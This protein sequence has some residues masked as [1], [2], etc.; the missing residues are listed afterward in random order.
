MIGPRASPV[1][2]VIFRGIQRM[3]RFEA[4]DYLGPENAADP[5]RASLLALFS[6]ISRTYPPSGPNS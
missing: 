5:R 3:F 6:L 4:P 1:G 2:R